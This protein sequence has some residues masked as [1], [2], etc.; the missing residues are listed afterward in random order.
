MNLVLRY[1]ICFQSLMSIHYSYSQ[2]NIELTK[3]DTIK[4]EVAVSKEIITL[5]EGNAVFFKF[6]IQNITNKPIKIPEEY[7]I[8][9]GDRIVNNIDAEIKYKGEGN[10]PLFMTCNIDPMWGLNEEGNYGPMS[11][12]LNPDKIYLFENPISCYDFSAIGKYQIRFTL[13][14]KCNRLYG[15]TTWIN[16]VVVK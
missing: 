11:L 4:F 1:L 8:T 13:N 9:F 15:Q 12:I 3:R 7:I 10:A 2:G 6:K 14:K 16:L 5:K